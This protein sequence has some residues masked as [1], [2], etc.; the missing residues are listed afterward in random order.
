MSGVKYKTQTASRKFMLDGHW[1]NGGNRGRY[2]STV[3]HKK[4][5][6]CSY[7]L[8]EKLDKV[9]SSAHSFSPRFLVSRFPEPR[10][11]FLSPEAKRLRTRF[12]AN[13]TAFSP[14]PDGV[15]RLSLLLSVFLQ[16]IDLFAT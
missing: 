4:I 9:H 2:I 8:D 11:T 3:R 12:T 7:S 14:D 1:I 10:K 5:S 13:S 16:L 15:I 6:M